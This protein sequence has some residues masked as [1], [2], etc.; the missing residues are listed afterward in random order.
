MPRS[1]AMGSWKHPSD[2]LSKIEDTCSVPAAHLA[3]HAVG[4]R[5]HPREATFHV[6]DIMRIVRAVHDI[7]GAEYR[8]RHVKRVLAEN[9]CVGIDLAQVVA[10]PLAGLGARRGD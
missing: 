10:R 7:V 1:R 6:P 4:Q 9:D 5:I 8:Y 2:N 3:A